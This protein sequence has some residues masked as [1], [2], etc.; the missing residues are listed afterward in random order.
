MFK[1]KYKLL[2]ET[3]LDWPFPG[4]HKYRCK[5]K[6]YLYRHDILNKILGYPFLS[7]EEFDKE[8]S[9]LAACV[10]T[11]TTLHNLV[12][13]ETHLLFARLGID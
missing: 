13:E 12:N 1:I 6:T 11:L 2:F 9:D 3:F 7:E 10:G 8:H 4:R 5:D